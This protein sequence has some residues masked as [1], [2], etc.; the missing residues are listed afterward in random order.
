MQIR[1]LQLPSDKRAER[2]NRQRRDRNAYHTAQSSDHGR[3]L[4]DDADQSG[5]IGTKNAI[6]GEFTFAFVHGGREHSKQHDQPH[7]PEH[8]D[9][10]GHVANDHVQIGFRCGCDAPRIHVSEAFDSCCFGDVRSDLLG[11]VTVLDLDEHGGNGFVGIF[12][13]NGGMPHLG[14]ISDHV[15]NGLHVHEHGIVERRAGIGE[16]RRHGEFVPIE[17]DRVVARHADAGSC[18]DL[19]ALERAVE[20]RCD[21]RGDHEVGI[22]VESDDLD[23]LVA[24]CGGQR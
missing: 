17:F 21:P 1:Q 2:E 22:G 15:G 5:T 20:L 11:G 8:R 24:A 12:F 19:A 9:E 10:K 6:R 23:F 18:N 14:G 3:F 13:R 16:L 7:D 4:H